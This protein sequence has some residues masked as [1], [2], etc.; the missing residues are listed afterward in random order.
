MTTG[1]WFVMLVAVG[2]MTSLL[3]WCIFRV[4]RE[5]QA[6]QKLHSQADIDPHD[7]AS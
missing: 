2:G 7:Q 3:V 5:P 1:G 4:M 6:T